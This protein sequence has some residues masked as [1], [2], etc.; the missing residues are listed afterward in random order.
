MGRC[1]PTSQSGGTWET[2]ALGLLSARQEGIV[3]RK[4]LE[5]KHIEDS[6]R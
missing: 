2:G 6:R 4:G 1:R 5:S 3:C